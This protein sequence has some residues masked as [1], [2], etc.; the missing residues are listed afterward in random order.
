MDD[1]FPSNNPPPRPKCKHSYSYNVYYE[2]LR[3]TY[4]AERVCTECGK[5]DQ[6]PVNG[7]YSSDEIESWS[8]D[9]I[10][11]YYMR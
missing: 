5:R 6:K 11:D 2:A 1:I 4:I 8:E 10:I 3:D 7:D 9:D